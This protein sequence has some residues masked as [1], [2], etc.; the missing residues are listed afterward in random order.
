M[1][2]VVRAEGKLSIA[3]PDGVA[4]PPDLVFSLAVTKW[5][6][7][8]TVTIA[9]GVTAQALIV[10]GTQGLTTIQALLIKSDQLI[11]VSYNSGTAFQV[12][13]GGFHLLAGTSLTGVT[14]TNA[15]GST[16]NVTYIAGGV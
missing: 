2:G 3:G 4:G 1:A 12:S 16:A 14:I 7:P 11:T 10:I 9:T 5:F 8:S 6:G 13:A 15:S